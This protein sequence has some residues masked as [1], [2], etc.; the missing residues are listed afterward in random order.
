ME[1]TN[2][3]YYKV[4]GDGIVTVTIEFAADKKCNQRDILLNAAEA[5]K[6]YADNG[7]HKS[8]TRKIKIDWAVSMIRSAKQKVDTRK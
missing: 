2:K 1:L 4:N 7:Q 3:D 6:F 5:I 8:W